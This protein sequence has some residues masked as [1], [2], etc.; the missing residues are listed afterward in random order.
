MKRCR[1]PFGG[2]VT[3]FALHRGSASATCSADK[4]RSAPISPENQHLAKR[5][6]FFMEDQMPAATDFLQ[7]F[8]VVKV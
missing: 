5:C 2:G 7:D 3:I 4:P 6:V 8:T 1:Q